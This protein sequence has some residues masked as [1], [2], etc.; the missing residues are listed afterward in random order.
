MKTLLILGAT[1]LVGRQILAAALAHPDVTRT[2]APTRRA[3]PA[4]ARGK[5]ELQNPLVDFESLPP[6][7]EWWRAEA[8][9]CALGT[10]L[11]QAGSRAA[12]R[13]VDHDYVL[14]AARLARQ[15]GTPAFVLCSSVGADPLSASF[16]LRV[17]GETE[18][19]LAELGFASL[20]LLRPSLLDGGPR[21]EARPGEAAGLWLARALRPLIPRR[22]RSVTPRAVATSMLDAALRGVEGVRAVDSE[23]IPPVP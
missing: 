1:G 2:V 17:K 8:M 20:T 7:A 16:Y 12:F 9:L 11:R 18:R 15:A 6:Q 14:A 10:T 5:A 23:Q 4:N 3:L 19:D 13:R 22:Y 21:P